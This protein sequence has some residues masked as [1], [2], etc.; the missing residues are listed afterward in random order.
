MAL[1]I[2]SDET[3]KLARELSEVTGESITTAVTVAL[4]ERLARVRRR[5]SRA[6]ETEIDEIF[7]RAARAPVED[8][9]TAE[10]IV[11]YNEIGA[12]D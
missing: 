1:N 3:D 9:R 12:F 7:A 11:G 2:K 4:K 5:R 8:N 6:W 10:E